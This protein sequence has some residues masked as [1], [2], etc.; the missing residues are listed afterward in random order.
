MAKKEPTDIVFK[1]S[2]GPSR[3]SASGGVVVVL[4][5]SSQFIPQFSELLTAQQKGMTLDITAKPVVPEQ[6][7]V[8]EEKKEKKSS[9]RKKRTYHQYQKGKK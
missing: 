1:A 3:I 4:K 9:K 6:P 7:A 5:L 2:I 8:V